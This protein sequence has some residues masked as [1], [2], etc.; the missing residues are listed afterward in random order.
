MEREIGTLLERTESIQKT[1]AMMNETLH[2]KIDRHDA[3]ISTVEM[4]QYKMVGVF[5]VLEVIGIAFL[6]WVRE[7]F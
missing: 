6:A 5:A 2:E 4:W 1:L 7:R 3:R